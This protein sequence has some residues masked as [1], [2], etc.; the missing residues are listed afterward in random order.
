MC[1]KLTSHKPQPRA[2]EM[3]GVL[4]EQAAFGVL[5]I[6]MLDTDV[7]PAEKRGVQSSQEKME[8][9]EGLCST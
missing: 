1:N 3:Y 2:E 5:H 8:W 4:E 9:K 7:C 6:A